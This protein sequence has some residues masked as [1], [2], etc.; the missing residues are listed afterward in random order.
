MSPTRTA[1]AT[2]LR[3]TRTLYSLS[4]F[5]GRPRRHHQVRERIPE[6]RVLPDHGPMGL[7]VAAPRRCRSRLRRLGLPRAVRARRRGRCAARARPPRALL[8][9]R[10][11]RIGPACALGSVAVR[12][13]SQSRRLSPGPRRAS[14]SREQRAALP[15]AGDPARRTLRRARL[16][17]PAVDP[18]RR[19]LVERVEAQLGRKPLVFPNGPE[20]DER[21]AVCSGGA[22]RHVVEAAAEGYDCYITGEPAEPPA[23]GKGSRSALRRRGPLR[24][25][26]PRRSGAR[27][28]KRR[29]L[30][31]RVGVRRPTE[32][33]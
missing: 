29:A 18:P 24:D 22:A 12:R 21:V 4:S 8:G 15:R 23:L 31:P 3:Y 10:S 14:G 20:L 25:R 30:R 28:P 1:R 9:Q 7:Q 32:P 11:R 2:R 19:N 6:P 33:V 13:R 5:D 17:R 26:D 16:R 27:R